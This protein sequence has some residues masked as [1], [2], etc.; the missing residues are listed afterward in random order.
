MSIGVSSD[1]KVLLKLKPNSCDISI[2]SRSTYKTRLCSALL[3]KYGQKRHCSV[4]EEIGKLKGEDISKFRF[5]LSCIESHFSDRYFD[6]IL[7]LIPQALR[8]ECRKTYK[9][10]DGINNIFNLAYEVLSWRVQ[11]A[12]IKAKL[13]PYLGFL[14]SITKGKPSLICD[15][16]ELYR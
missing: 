2:S 14:H 12:L 1:F 15:F 4:V 5:R 10:Y 7:G 8:P 3:S 6:Q 13:E 16:M 9:A 11:H